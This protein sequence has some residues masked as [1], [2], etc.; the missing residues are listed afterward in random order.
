M[1]TGVGSKKPSRIINSLKFPR[2]SLQLP[3]KKVPSF[4]AYYI[5]EISNI[6]G[7]FYG[8]DSKKKKLKPEQT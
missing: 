7:E 4:W 6:S 3:L 2:F 8:S 1:I 5:S